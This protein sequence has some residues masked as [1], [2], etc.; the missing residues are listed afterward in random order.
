M[1][2]T[3][4]N[5]LEELRMRRPKQEYDKKDQKPQKLDGQNE[6][7]DKLGQQKQQ[8]TQP[9]SNVFEDVIIKRPNPDCQ[10]EQYEG[11]FQQHKNQRNGLPKQSQ[12]LP[13]LND[14]DKET[15][16]K[17]Q[18]SA[19]LEQQYSF[20]EE[21]I[22]NP[23][24]KLFNAFSGNDDIRNIHEN[25]RKVDFE[26][27]AVGGKESCKKCL[28]AEEISF[29]ME[30]INNPLKRVHPR[31]TF[32]FYEILY[33]SKLSPCIT[34]EIMQEI[35]SS[36]GVSKSTVEHKKEVSIGNPNQ[37]NDEI[38]QL[39]KVQV[40]LPSDHNTQMPNSWQDY[41]HPPKFH[42]M[43]TLSLPS[44]NNLGGIDNMHFI[45]KLNILNSVLKSVSDSLETVPLSSPPN[46]KLDGP[47][48]VIYETNV[49]KYEIENHTHFK[50]DKATAVWGRAM[51]ILISGS[52]AVIGTGTLL[53]STSGFSASTA[54]AAGASGLSQSIL[55]APVT[56]AV[57]AISAASASAIPVA[58]A[59]AVKATTGG[60]SA[61]TSTTSALA[62]T[63]AT[64]PMP[65]SAFSSVSA[66]VG[67]GVLLF[68]LNKAKGRYL[69][70]LPYS[71]GEKHLSLL[72]VEEEDETIC[73]YPIP[74]SSS[75]EMHD[76][77]AFMKDVQF[78]SETP[79]SVACIRLQWH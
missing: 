64:A 72:T 60:F 55:V 58:E 68:A 53:T 78:L 42:K 21:R 61:L 74:Q 28:H 15:V 12:S 59:L 24:T 45:T 16:F 22:T 1:K 66:L 5:F 10:K 3:P 71:S 43:R 62:A 35:M 18:E 56:S 44:S 37:G 8:M 63:P 41:Q 54:E 32:D 75:Q 34:D 4:T 2:K 20:A 46:E 40:T 47:L 14:T 39:T 51:D 9:P 52:S 65:A 31:D 19:S 6:Q 79:E 57:T 50:N 30:N 26:K 69:V 73:L 67:A 48:T 70:S 17:T 29:M 38:T 77:I 7:L 33:D 11:L 27:K 36:L 25:Y 23:L 13:Q 76:S 49:Q